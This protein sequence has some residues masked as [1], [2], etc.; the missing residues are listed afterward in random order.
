MKQFVVIGIGNFGYYLA[1]E[2]YAKGYEVVAIDNDPGPIQE[3]KDKVSQAVVADATDLKA[4]EG[5]GIREMDAAV[6]C[7]G[8]SL[9]HSILAT[10]NS[11][12][13][14]V[15]RVLAKAISE[16]HGR[17]L[18]KVGASEVLFPEKD[19]AI[20]VARRLHNPNM[21]DYLPLI[22]G[23]SII[24]LAP[25]EDF[26]GKRLMDVDLINKYGVQVVAI[27]EIV[28]DHMNI[29]PTGNYVLKGSDL[30]ILLGPD[31]SL[32]KLRKKESLEEK[33]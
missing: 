4:L 27:K 1:T 30:M 2:L 16:A 32:E 28:P 9:S 7:I 17:I 6:I 26:I 25:L 10:L 14:G 11:L 33:K 19:L 18:H 29:I 8:S 15:K 5:V 24:Q 12:D 13:L 20:T 21:I 31:E 22:D 23:Y 3:I